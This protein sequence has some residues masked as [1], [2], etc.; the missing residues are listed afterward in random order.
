[1]IRIIERK[2]NS[3]PEGQ[4]FD[5]ITE[6]ALVQMGFCQKWIGRNEEAARTFARAVQTIKPTP[7]TVVVPEANGI[8]S[9]LAMA[10]AGLG[11][12]QKAL[13]QARQAIKDYE[14]DSVN[15]P[16]AEIALAQIQAQFGD[17]DSAIAVLPHLL[18]VPAGITP[19]DLRFNP[20]WDP[21]R[22]DPRFEALLAANKSR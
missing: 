14:T 7:D 12:K 3:I 11:E 20:M 22:K 10:Y 15:K 17:L 21:L 1:M 16:L 13:D 2:L 9:T 19:A 8:P 4:P 6:G 18:Q 5:S